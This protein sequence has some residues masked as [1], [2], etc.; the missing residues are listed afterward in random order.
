MIRSRCQTR[1]SQ[2]TSTAATAQIA[3]SIAAAVFAVSAVVAVPV[4]SAQ[5]TAPAAAPQA[6]ADPN[7]GAVTVAGSLDFVSQYMFRGIRQHSTGIALWPVLDL[8]VAAFSG[9]GGVKSVSLNAGSWNSLHTGD[10]GTDGPSTKFWYESDFYT[11]FTLGFGGGVSFAT[12]YTAYTSPNNS[13]STVKELMF[14]LGID[15]TAALGKGAVKPYVI[16]AQELD[17]APG[18][19][20]ADSGT[21]AG[22]YLELGVSPGY[23]G[24]KASVAFPVKVG[25]SLGNYY[26]LQ[27]T[28]HAFGFFSIAGL[29]TVP[30]GST[31]RF[32]AWNV[33]FGG[34]FQKLGD[35]TKA[36]NGDKG[37]RGI[38]SFGIGFSY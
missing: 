22:T 16:I 12:T 2:S 38:G 10:T 31:T 30:I 18:L 6:P 33:H 17:T 7:P 1:S 23:S 9:E 21:K 34:E 3:A 29:V 28:D 27:G 8:G 24:A 15:D 14:K 35:T 25:L 13:Y 20:Q 4:A 37:T 26:E 32:G 11:T 5:T 36:L 19:G